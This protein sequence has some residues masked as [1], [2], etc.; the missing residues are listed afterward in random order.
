MDEGFNTDWTMEAVLG[1]DLLVPKDWIYAE[2]F[3]SAARILAEHAGRSEINF[4]VFPII[5]NYRQYFELALKRM[6]TVCDVYDS[7][8]KDAPV[9]HTAVAPIHDLSKL[10]GSVRPR[11]LAYC[12]DEPEF[13]PIDRLVEHLN[14]LDPS[15]EA[16][17][18]ATTRKGG[19]LHTVDRFDVGAF[20]N[21]A[22]EAAQLLVGCEAL[23]DEY[24]G[25]H[26]ELLN[27]LSP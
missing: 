19:T 1:A 17:R 12:G 22:E 13:A 26:R 6:H 14:E 11:L 2:G 18:Y 9:E 23:L 27:E 25:L 21:M 20:V 7:V 10:W 4:L 8:V 5:F 3:R 24:A 15:S 16:S